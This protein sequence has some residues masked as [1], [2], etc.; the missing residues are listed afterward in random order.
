MSLKYIRRSVMVKFKN[1]NVALSS[2]EALFSEISGNVVTIRN[3][4]YERLLWVELR[5]RLRQTERNKDILA[6]VYGL[7]FWED[8]DYNIRQIAEFYG[9]SQGRVISVAKECIRNLKTVVSMAQGELDSNLLPLFDK[10]YLY[11]RL[12]KTEELKTLN[13]DPLSRDLYYLNL[14]T[15]TYNVLKRRGI[16]CLK[17]L[18]I[19]SKEEL[20]KV[21]GLGQTSYNEVIRTVRANNLLFKGEENDK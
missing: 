12:I 7:G 1:R 18:T 8:K 17:D 15:R 11:N 21:R 10:R 2:Y 19:M 14:S 13:Q 9:L 6:M 16:N 3:R 5:G 4:K 20:K